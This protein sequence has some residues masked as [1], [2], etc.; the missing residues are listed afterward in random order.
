MRRLQRDVP[1]LPVGPGSNDGP[2]PMPPPGPQLEGEAP[3][4]G[5]GQKRGPSVGESSPKG[6]LDLSHIRFNSITIVLSVNGIETLDNLTLFFGSSAFYDSFM[7]F[8]QE[9]LKFLTDCML[10]LKDL[11]I[12]H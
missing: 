12:N 3:G 5:H 4:P 6:F 8:S 11:I 7:T 2:G 10:N 1:E 9:K